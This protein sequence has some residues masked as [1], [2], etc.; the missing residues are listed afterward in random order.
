MMFSERLE[1][2]KYDF[3]YLQGALRCVCGRQKPAVLSVYNDDQSVWGPNGG[4]LPS[5]NEHFVNFSKR[6]KNIFRWRKFLNFFLVIRKFPRIPKIAL[7][8]SCDEF[9]VTKN[10]KS[11][12]FY[13]F[14]LI[15]VIFSHVLR[16][17][18]LKP[19]RMN[20]NALQIA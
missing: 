4:L 16:I 15:L 1:Y 10:K 17:S 7:R 2:G 19:N 5:P 11:T 8:K 13:K 9:K 6:R 18:T 20:G 12:F 14:F 3:Q